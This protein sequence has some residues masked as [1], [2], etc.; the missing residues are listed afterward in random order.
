MI[1]WTDYRYIKRHLKLMLDKR[2]VKIVDLI[3]V[4]IFK[5]Y[6]TYIFSFVGNCFFIISEWAPLSHGFV[7]AFVNRI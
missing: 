4:F 6:S 7:V 3:L 1:P 2:S 5:I